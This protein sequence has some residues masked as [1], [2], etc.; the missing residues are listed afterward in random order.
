[1]HR[2]LLLLSLLLGLATSL[3]AQTGQPVAGEQLRDRVLA[4]VGDTVLLLSDVQFQLARLESEG[5]LPQDPAEREAAAEQVMQSE[6][7]KLMLV[8][9]AREAGL[10]VPEDVV[11]EQVDQ[12]LRDLERDFGSPMAFDAALIAEGMTRDEYRQMLINGSRDDQMVQEIMRARLGSRAR[13]TI[14]ES[15]IVAF[16]EERR[17]GLPDRPATISFQQVVVAPKP[18]AE[19]REAAMAEVQQVFDELEAGTEFEVLARRFSDDTGSA[20]HGGDLGWFRTG[21]MVPEFERVAYS[22]RPGETSGVVETMFGFHIIRLERMRGAERQASHILI[23]PEITPE[24]VERARLSADS[25]A[26]AIRDGASFTNLASRY[27]A[28]EDQTNI[29]SYPVEQLTAGYT[30]ALRDATVGQIVGPVE[31]EDPR[32]NRWAVIRVTARGE[33]GATTLDDVRDQIRDVLQ[34]QKMQEQ[35]LEELRQEVH[36]EI[37]P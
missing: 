27:N 7:N 25:V 26:Q 13:P 16:F 28:A 8:E 17:S 36:V 37:L 32:G 19:A 5:Q 35:L 24:D 15:E 29:E 9:A 4:V 10:T 6:V 33:A 34:N 20:E 11:A 18:S 3:S 14:D 1:M 12:Q 30:E 23:E 2:F 21:R 22:L 31:L